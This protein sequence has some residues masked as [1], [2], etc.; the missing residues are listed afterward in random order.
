MDRGLG[1]IQEEGGIA[2]SLEAPRLCPG[3]L[4]N[5]ESYWVEAAIYIN[6][7]L[8]IMATT[9]NAHFKPPH[10]GFVWDTAAAQQP[11][12]YAAR[13]PPHPPRPLV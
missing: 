2:A 12:L 10:E 4:V 3:Q 8:N 6:D 1:L 13:L 7:C 9:V 5:L 11:C